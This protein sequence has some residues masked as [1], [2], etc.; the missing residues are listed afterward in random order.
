MTS[1]TARFRLPI[2][3]FNQEPWHDEFDLLCRAIDEMVYNAILGNSPAWANSTAYVIGDVV[4]DTANGLMYT[5]AV[6]HT[7]PPLPTTFA[8]FRAANP[9]Y[10]NPTVIVPTQRGA[11]SGPGTTYVV[12]DFVTESNR[13]AVCLVSHISSATFNTDLGANKWSILV[14]LSAVAATGINNTPE[15]SIAVAATTNIGAAA[16]SRVLVS[17]SGVTVTSFG[18]VANS[19]KILRFD[20]ANTITHNATTLVLAN[21]IN[22]V[23]AP[24]DML[25]ITSNNAGNWKEISRS[26]YAKT[27]SVGLVEL[28]TTAEATVGTDATRP[29]TPAG[30]KQAFDD[31]FFPAGTAMIFFQST[32]PT[33]WTKAT[34]HDNKALRIVTGNSGG[35]S[36]GTSPFT[37]VFGITATQTY[38][39]GTADIPAHSHGITEPNAGAGHTHN[40][41]S[42]GDLFAG[43]TFRTGNSTHPFGQGTGTGM[44][45]TNSAVTGI[46][47]NNNTGGGGSHAH[48]IDLRVQYIDCIVC[49]KN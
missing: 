6:A 9:T 38:T 20:G 23:T 47:I 10:W 37:T 8:T 31:R 40:L 12:G 42:A 27:D 36:A 35:A 41:E 32:A 39:L 14:D 28:A 49:T 44:G 11:W 30:F 7:S 22:M 13:Y 29:I 33:G 15:T 5:A 45:A 24:G 25:M 46:T 34:T 48:N 1:Y 2:P 21:N 19:I 3:D 16:P 26:A 18:N 43:A 4:I 17:G